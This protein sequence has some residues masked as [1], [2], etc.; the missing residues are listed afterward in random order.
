MQVLDC[1]LQEMDFFLFMIFYEFIFI[2]AQKG[3]DEQHNIGSC[4]VQVPLLVQGA[5]PFQEA[6]PSSRA[7][8]QAS[9]VWD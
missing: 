3:C 4:K 8:R 6:R 5:S 7:E 1:P 9:L 2:E